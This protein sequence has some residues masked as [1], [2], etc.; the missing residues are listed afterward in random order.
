MK[1]LL[2]TNICIYFLNGDHAI[3]ERIRAVG[4]DALC[5]TGPVLS[6]L[7]F[8]A[9]NSARPRENIERVKQFS[10]LVDFL[11]DT[12]ESAAQFG[13]IKAEL[14]RKGKP[15]DDIDIFIAAAA[16]DHGAVLV[17]NNVSH[18]SRIGGLAI[19]NWKKR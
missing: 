11:S 19:E 5:I 15:V 7:F 4:A 1:Y 10:R 3:A 16:L 2:D 13:K 9:Y 12:P 6:E 8:G 18:F 17:T 14:R